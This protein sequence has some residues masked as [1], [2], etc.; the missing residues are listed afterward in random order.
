MVGQDDDGTLVD[1]GLGTD[2]NSLWDSSKVVYVK[3]GSYPLL[4]C[5]KGHYFVSRLVTQV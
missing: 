4:I 2:T 3:G 5:A 1:Q